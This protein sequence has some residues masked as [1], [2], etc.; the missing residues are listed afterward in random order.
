MEAAVHAL[1]TKDLFWK[2]CLRSGVGFVRIGTPSFLISRI[3]TR[4][5]FSK[6][7]LVLQFETI[8][9]ILTAFPTDRENI[10]D[11]RPSLD[12]KK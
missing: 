7:A 2:V 11:R 9:F 6:A 4:E 12:E 5:H 10:L 1:S 3:G 8:H